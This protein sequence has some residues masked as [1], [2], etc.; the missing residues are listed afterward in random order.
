MTENE[1]LSALSRA[2]LGDF[3]DYENL[4]TRRQVGQ[5][6]RQTGRAI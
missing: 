2:L 3:A 4:Q 5:S 6:R 1:K